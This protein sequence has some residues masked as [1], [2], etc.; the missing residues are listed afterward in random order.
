MFLSG[1]CAGHV[2]LVLGRR[3]G[4]RSAHP[5]G[6][7][8]TTGHDRT[9]VLAARFREAFSCFDRYARQAFASAFGSVT[10]LVAQHRMK[11]RI[12]DVVPGRRSFQFVIDD[13]N[14]VTVSF[15]I[16]GIDRL[17][18]SCEYWT[19]GLGRVEGVRSTTSL[20]QADRRWGEA[21]LLMALEGFILKCT[22]ARRHREKAAFVPLRPAL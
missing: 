9:E 17:E 3:V 4:G 14:H 1:G 8:G 18:C 2:H 15:S 13:R 16:D 20:R 7:M 19:A 22:A 5:E 12:S 10:R 21:C 6:T 11:V